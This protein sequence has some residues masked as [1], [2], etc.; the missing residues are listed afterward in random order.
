[1][2]GIRPSFGIKTFIWSCPPVHC[3]PESLPPPRSSLPGIAKTNSWFHF[4]GYSFSIWVPLPPQF[5]D[6]LEPE[7]LHLFRCFWFLSLLRISMP[8][9][10]SRVT[11]PSQKHLLLDSHLLMGTQS[12]WCRVCVHQKI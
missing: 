2:L 1:M 11:R 7:A 5:E 9:Y 6:F 12:C 8:D 10:L 4:Y 3:L